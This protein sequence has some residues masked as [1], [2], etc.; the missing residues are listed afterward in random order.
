[1]HLAEVGLGKV[2]KREASLLNAEKKT[3]LMQFMLAG[4]TIRTMPRK[5]PAASR[6]RPLLVLFI[7][8]RVSHKRHPMGKISKADIFNNIT[9]PII[10]YQSAKI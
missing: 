5:P 9:L 10:T 2:F 3:Y 4:L 8:Y 1:M 6:G 7:M